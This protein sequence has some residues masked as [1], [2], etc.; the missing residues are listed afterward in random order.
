MVRSP[1]LLGGRVGEEAGEELRMRWSTE[2]GLAHLSPYP[3]ISTKSEIE[4][5]KL[6]R[7]PRRNSVPPL[8]FIS[9]LD[10]TQRHCR[11]HCFCLCSQRYP[12]CPQLS[13]ASVPLEHPTNKSNHNRDQPHSLNCISLNPCCKTATP[14]ALR[15]KG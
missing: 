14:G 5:M 10:G 6:E 11:T 8:T 1:P 3:G 2:P 15:S 7:D 4:S 9:C 13:C 12:N